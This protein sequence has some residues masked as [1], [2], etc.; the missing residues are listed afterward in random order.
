LSMTVSRNFF[1]SSSSRDSDLR[2]TALFAQTRTPDLAQPGRRPNG[3]RSPHARRRHRNG[4]IND[5]PAARLPILASHRAPDIYR[6]SVWLK[7]FESG[8]NLPLRSE[9]AAWIAQLVS[10]D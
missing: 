5:V 7:G 2:S 9:N 10:H 8:K 4:G 1:V 6:P 3:A